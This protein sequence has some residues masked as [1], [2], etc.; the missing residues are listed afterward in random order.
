MKLLKSCDRLPALA[1]PVFLSLFMIHCKKAD[2]S[3]LTVNPAFMEKITAFTSGVISSESVIQI[4]LAEDFPGGDISNAPAGEGLFRFKPSIKGQ[5]V[6]VDKRTIEFRPA[7]KLQSGK[8]YAA[9]FYLSKILRVPKELAMLEF[10]FSVVEQA[11]AVEMEGYQTHNENDLVWNRIRGTV[12][13]ADVADAEYL[14]NVFIARQEDR[15]LKIS[16]ESG[17]DRRSFNFL[18]DSVRR[19][20]KPGKVEISWDATADYSGIKGKS[21]VDIPSLGDYKVMDVKII[22]QPEQYVQIIFSDPVKKNQNFEGLIFLDNNTSLEFSV[23]GNFIKAFPVVRQSGE[24]RITIREGLTNI[25]G[26]GLKQA[27]SKDIT[28]E[29]PKPAVR[30]SGKGVILPSTKG[31]VF[32]F[33]AVNLKAVDVKIIRIFESNIGHFLQV[34]RLDGSNQLKRAGR[35]MHRQTLTLTNVPADLGKWNRFYLDLSKLIEPD[36]GSIYRIEISFRKKYS[37]YPCESANEEEIAE[38]ETDG[39]SDEMEELSYWDSYEEY[40]DDYYDYNYDYEWEERDNPCSSSY[41]QPNRWVARNILA[42][43]LGIVVKSGTDQALFCAV[44]NLVTSQPTEGVEVTLY[45]FQQQPIVSGITDNNG[46][47]SLDAREKPFLLIA[48]FEK[49]RG[50]LRL[51]DGSSLSLGAFDVSG[52]AVPGGLKGFLYGERGV[53]RPGD[54]LFLTF[55]LEDKQHLLP[56]SHPIVFEMY[57]PKGQLFSRVT[58]TAGMDGFYSWQM[59]TPSDAPTGNWNLVV[60]VGGTQFSRNLRIET[61]KPNRLKIDLKFD[62]ERLSAANPQAQGHLTAAWL[63]G[64]LAPGLKASVSVMLTQAATGFEKYPEYQFTDPSRNFE[65]EEQVLY[66]G[67]TDEKG[68]TPVPCRI[69]T[70]QASPGMLQANF[71]VRVFEKGGDFSIDRFSIP[72]SP[73]V[74][75]VGV[76]TPPGDKRGMLL[77]DTTQWIDVVLLSE[78]GMPLSRP[79]IEAYVYK[80]D[81][82]NWWE[83]AGDELAEFVGNTYNRPLVVKTLSVVNGRG[84]FGFRIDRPDWG[85]F[86]IRVVDP[87]SGHSAGRIV[88]IDWPGWAGRPMR[89]N[90]EAASML[91]FNADKEKYSVGETAEITIPTSGQ[92]RVLFT[93]ESGSR[94]LLHQWLQVNGK[95]IR[96]QFQVTSDMTP[97]VY[98]CALLI[99]PH[100]NSENDMPMRLYGAIPIFAEDPKTRLV[101]VIKMPE[102][103]E[104]LKDFTVQVSEKNGKEMTYTLALVE[105]GLLGLT[106]FKTPDPWSA[107]YAREALGVKSWDLYDAVIGAY[108][109]KL[110]SLLG[111]GG[112]EDLVPG[113][114][115]E[116]ANRF[117]PVVRYLGPYTL[118]AG[119]ISSHK[120]VMPNYIGSV[121]TMVV[122]GKGGAYGFAE[123]TVPVKKPLMVLATL[124]RVLGPGESVS[125]PVTIF[126]MDMQVKQ[127]NVSVKTNGLLITEG[128]GSKSVSFSQP[129]EKMVDFN[130]RIASKTGIARVQVIA[131]SGKHTSTY[132]LELNVRNANPPVTTFTGGSTEAGKTWE[133]SFDLPGMENTNTAVLEVSGIPP[134][135]AGRRI[136]YLITYPHGCIEQITSAAFPQLFLNEFLELD[137]KTKSAID[138]HIKAGISKLRTFQL[139]GGGFAYWP[140]NQQI[141]SWGNS[142]A[143]HF[144]LEAEKKGYALPA[145]LKSGWLRSQK[146]LARQWTPAQL[147]DPWQQDDLEQAYR[148]YTLALAGEP[149]TGAMNR[150]R[151]VKT[152]SLQAKWR[153]AAAYAIT[154]QIPVAKELVSRESTDIQEYNGFYSSY[155][156]RERDWAMMLETMTLLKDQI[157]GVI[158]ARKISGVL[159]SGSWMSTQ[160]TSYCLMA[161]AKFAQ[162]KA[163]GKMEFSYRLDDGKVMTV[164]STKPLVQVPLPMPRNAKAGQI[165]VI[166]KGQGILFTRLIMEGI[167]EAG[168]EKEF[169]NN[170]ALEIHYLN[171]DGKVLDISRLTQGT[172]F[173]AVVTVLNPGMLD[174]RELALTQVFPP[175]WEIMNS[176]LSGFE[177]PEGI[178]NAAYQDIRDDRIYTYFDLKRGERKTF[179][180]QLN[181][182]YTGR[183]YLPGIFCEAM[184][185]NTI[186]VMKKG[187]WVE[188]VKEGI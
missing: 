165:T 33:E 68:Q 45:N 133:T 144:L 61:V 105:E 100:A 175:G 85:R 63:H 140:G 102:V 66:E 18:I 161:M 90:P 141:N 153:L 56:E 114:S 166:N 126:A 57:N 82:R 80:L 158:L 178:A 12:N 138:Q 188:V 101:P 26:Y 76:K 121:R 7:E 123:K 97:N 73:Y 127:V 15:K 134:L 146:Q 86:Y 103:L 36:P 112:D 19:T 24:C 129:G 44:T 137:E 20:E 10:N 35:L 39:Y 152:L 84:R 185:D 55:M 108:G 107:F 58:R 53:W 113:E 16:W 116:K 48:K 64:A 34:N 96:H 27:Y 65:Y 11:F 75:Y 163:S 62:P 168:N 179:T 77:T 131:G 93:I 143:G 182:A 125:L 154:G 159:S 136:K 43:D 177:V 151:E 92:G 14:K 170:L 186:S 37:L 169:S 83:S 72:F 46:F 149:E 38:S 28:F 78:T 176:R 3:A 71:T 60:K 6:W 47:V 117:K 67:Y 2:Q 98:A 32:P 22:Q 164:S 13:T 157:R 41:Y 59:A 119:K 5:A 91:T 4:V 110:S 87:V 180:V 25:L 1:I 52:S 111:I 145:E 118:K 54:T 8:T 51:D 79:G 120:I 122:A 155:G 181:A 31:M 135:D 156:S 142:Y 40:Y 70:D 128:P 50:Y 30:L 89:D 104:P 160:S 88:Y 74:A 106:R 115:A 162:V 17:Q 174:Y 150:L 183:Y 42:S 148:L 187:N 109:G 81:W 99:Q 23:A 132:D 94:V 130:L 147:K 172:D 69:E 29:V 49:Q 124:P 21:E 173:I 167:P 9:R 95:E 171:R 139:S 184:Y